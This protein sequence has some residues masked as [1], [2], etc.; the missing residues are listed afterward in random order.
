ME[1]RIFYISTL[2]IMLL[3]SCENNFDKVITYNQLSPCN[4][5]SNTN[6]DKEYLEWHCEECKKWKAPHKEDLLEVFEAMDTLSNKYERNDY[7]G[8]FH[9]CE[10]NGK[11]LINS[12]EYDY[13]LN[14]A[15]WVTLKNEDMDKESFLGCNSEDCKKY[16]L[17][18]RLTKAEIEGE[19]N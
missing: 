13:N 18:I 6:I 12:I 9:N 19:E 3:F 8:Y 10:V 1:T 2:L 5:E 15:G 14:A 7:F 16:F 4:L 17:S 11:V